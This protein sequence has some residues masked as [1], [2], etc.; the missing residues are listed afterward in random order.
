MNSPGLATSESQLRYLGK[1]HLH[2]TKENP[3][4]ADLRY[5]EEDSIS[6]STL[7]WD[8]YFQYAP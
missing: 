3:A 4:F 7:T 2:I 5:G 1:M 6:P 8:I